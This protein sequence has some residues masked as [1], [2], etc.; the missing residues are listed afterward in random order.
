[1][2]VAAGVVVLFI[3]LK[4]WGGGW[5]EGKWLA[6]SGVLLCRCLKPKRGEGRRG[7]IILVGEMKK[8]GRQFSS[9]TRTRRRAADGDAGRGGDGSG[10]VE[11]EE[12]P[13]GLV[14]GRKAKTS[15]VSAKI[16]QENGS[17]LIGM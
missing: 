15:W 11:E 17:D 6:G 4:R 1:V 2:E 3:G 8:A 13:G 16:F 7:G 5:S 14:M 12:G 10:E 9:A